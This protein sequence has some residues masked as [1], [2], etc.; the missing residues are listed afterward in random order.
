MQIIQDLSLSELQ[1]V[2]EDL[3]QPKYRAKQ[4]FENIYNGKTIDSISNIPKSLKDE[5]KKN[6]I[7]TPITIYTTQ[8]SEDGTQKFAYKLFDGNIVEGVLL[9]YKYG[10]TLCI[11]CQVGCAMGCKFCAS[12][13]GG[14]VRNLS[15]GE[16]LGQI[17]TVNAMLGGTAKKRKITNV[18]MMGSGEP[19][20]NF[21][22]V[23]K[24]LRLVT[25]E[26]G[27]N[28]SPR[29]ISVS[30]CGI[31]PNI[32]KL[33]ELNLPLILTISLHAPNDKIRKQ[34]MPIANRYSI[35][36]IIG[37]AKR[38]FNKTGRRV[39]F[40]YALTDGVNNTDECARELAKL[41]SGFPT[42]VNLIPLNEVEERTLKTVTRKSAYQF[43][44]K[45]KKLG[46]SVTV[47]RTIADDIDGACGQLRNRI[48]KEENK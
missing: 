21:E 7:D 26:D 14:L 44:E 22:N 11:S 39:V 47:R 6:F 3:G 36:T 37:A 15:A 8:E 13:L 23:S 9:N 45:L 18:V 35:K 33:A 16:I 25:S 31:V 42:H 34:I 20:D 1:Q 41:V 28:I 10:Y 4:I 5:L 27:I 48:L 46:V 17:L 12:T 38:C 29:N 32:D 40:E 30:T 19:L 24:F 43:A 2:V